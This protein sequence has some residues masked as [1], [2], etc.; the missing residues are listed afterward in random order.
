MRVIVSL[1]VSSLV[2]VLA[3]LVVWLFT[4]GDPNLAFLIPL[5]VGATVVDFVAG[6][7]MRVRVPRA[8]RIRL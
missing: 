3:F 8:E 5:C 2:G 6:A 4:S 1:F 7:G